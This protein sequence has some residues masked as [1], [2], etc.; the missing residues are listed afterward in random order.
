MAVFTFL[1]KW[2]VYFT[3]FISLLIFNH[4]VN[5]SIFKEHLTQEVKN[6]VLWSPSKDTKEKSFIFYFRK[7]FFIRLLWGIWEEFDFTFGNCSTGVPGVSAPLSFS[8]RGCKRNTVRMTEI[9]VTDCNLNSVCERV[10]RH[11]CVDDPSG[12]KKHTN[13]GAKLWGRVRSKLLRQKVTCSFI[14]SPSVTF[15]L[16]SFWSHS[17][18]LFSVSWLLTH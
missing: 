2:V 9:M 18:H 3:G 6:F 11:C 16:C 4:F 12:I 14:L 13:S 17:F 10:E 5:H 15:F 1:Q 8:V 7:V